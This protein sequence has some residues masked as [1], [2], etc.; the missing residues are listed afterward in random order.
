MN[1]VLGDLKAHP[2][3]ARKRP[4]AQN[5]QQHMSTNSIWGTAW[6]KL[7]W[8]RPNK[9]GNQPHETKSNVNSDDM[10]TESSTVTPT[11][12]LSSPISPKLDSRFVVRRRVP[13]KEEN[14]TESEGNTIGDKLRRKLKEEASEKRKHFREAEKLKVSKQRGTIEELYLAKVEVADSQSPTSDKVATPKRVIITR[15]VVSSPKEVVAIVTQKNTPNKGVPVMPKSV[16]VMSKSVPLISKSVPVTPKKVVTPRKIILKGTTPVTPATASNEVI[17][18]PIVFS[19]ITRSLV[20][21]IKNAQDTPISAPASDPVDL[22]ERSDYPK[23]EILRTKRLR[24]P[25]SLNDEEDAIYVSEDY[26]GF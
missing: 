20:V 24:K 15:R 7:L 13:K 14:T 21:P 26:E 11:P 6:I 5:K 2:N 22:R 1:H 12:L 10:E 4:A 23:Y 25:V 18:S 9:Q 8:Q 17:T 16:P 3:D 19:Q